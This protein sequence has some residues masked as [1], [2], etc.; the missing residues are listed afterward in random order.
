MFFYLIA[1]AGS[2]STDVPPPQPAV[3]PGASSHAMMPL[4][5]GQ[6]DLVNMLLQLIAQQQIANTRVMAPAMMPGDAQPIMPAMMPCGAPKPTPTTKIKIHK[7]CA[8]VYI[9]VG[10]FGYWCGAY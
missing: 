8:F 5:Q 1:I 10:L 7:D 2:A 3:Y 9:D 6:P 4:Q